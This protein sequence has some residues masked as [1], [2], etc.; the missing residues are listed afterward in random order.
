MPP[1]GTAIKKPSWTKTSRIARHTPATARAVR[2]L[3]WA[4]ILHAR[5]SLAGQPAS[6]AIRRLC[7]GEDD[8]PSRQSLMVDLHVAPPSN[9][10]PTRQ[11]RHYA[12]SSP[13]TTTTVMMSLAY[14]GVRPEIKRILSIYPDGLRYD[15]A[16]KLRVDSAFLAR[17]L[18]VRHHSRRSTAM[19]ELQ[20]IGAPQSN[21]VWVTRI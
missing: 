19:P 12:A 11:A 2:P 8:R 9:P 3:S 13:S 7:L 6:P 10:S 16:T 17:R 14:P 18:A 4:R 20:I 15:G 21:Y 5:A 1:R